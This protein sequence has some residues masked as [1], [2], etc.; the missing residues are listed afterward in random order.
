MIYVIYYFITSSLFEC[1]PLFYTKNFDRGKTLNP[2]PDPSVLENLD[3][4]LG[5]GLRP[6]VPD[7]WNYKI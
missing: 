4:D 1:S 3:P 5:T 6:T 2:D 7:G